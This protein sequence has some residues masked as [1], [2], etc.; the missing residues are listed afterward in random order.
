MST[1]RAVPVA[2]AHAQETVSESSILKWMIVALVIFA[3]ISLGCLIYFNG[4]I[5][6]PSASQVG[7]GEL[8]GYIFAGIVGCFVGIVTAKLS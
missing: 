1:P 3:V 7:L 6:D 2:A 4:I 5:A 8:F